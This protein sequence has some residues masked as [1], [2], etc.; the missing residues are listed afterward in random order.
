MEFQL[1]SE[2]VELDNLLKTMNL[3]E[4]GAEA[5]KFIQEGQ[6]KVNKEVEIR[7]RRKLRLGDWVEFKDEQIKIV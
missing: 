7:V 4:N 1:K 5:K 6:V 2:F 3:V